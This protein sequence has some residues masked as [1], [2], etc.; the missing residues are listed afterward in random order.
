LLNFFGKRNEKKIR[1]IPGNT[2]RKKEIP[3]CKVNPLKLKAN[4]GIFPNSRIDCGFVENKIK[5]PIRR[6][7][8]KKILREPVLFMWR[9]T[10]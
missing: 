5:Y 8:R 7:E 6:L 10:F 3:A 4:N 1:R 2:Y 9:I